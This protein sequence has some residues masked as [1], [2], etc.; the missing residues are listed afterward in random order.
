[1][2]R[3]LN[4]LERPVHTREV[5]SSSLSLATAKALDL[6]GLF[7]FHGHRLSGPLGTGSGVH[8][9]EE[10]AL[11]RKIF[12]CILILILTATLISGCSGKEPEK[13]S[14]SYLTTSE[15]PSIEDYDPGM[16]KASFISAPD[17]LK[18]FSTLP[19]TDHGISKYSVFYNMF[20]KDTSACFVLS[21]GQGLYGDMILVEIKNNSEG[22]F[23]ILKKAEGG[24]V[25][26]PDENSSPVE[27]PKLEG[28]IPGGLGTY[29]DADGSNC[30]EV[31]LSVED[32]QMRIYIN[33]TEAQVPLLTAASPSFDLGSIGVYKERSQS[34]AYID[35]VS[36]NDDETGT[37][38]SD[39][40][41][42]INDGSSGARIGS[43]FK[44]TGIKGQ[45][46]PVF[47]KNFDTRS[48][49][50]KRATLYLTALGSFEASLNGQRVSDDYLD[51][52]ALNFNT[53]LKYVAYDVTPFISDSNTLDITL[54][55]GW[56]DRALGYPESFSPWGDKPALKGEL[57]IEDKKGN[58]TII[59]T[60]ESF[61][62][63]TNG[64]LRFDDIYQGE[65][66]DASYPVTI[67]DGSFTEVEVDA[68]DPSY[69]SLPVTAKK[70]SP[71]RAVETLNPIS[72]S[73]PVPG[74]FV[75]DF[76]TNAVGNISIDLKGQNTDGSSVDLSALGAAQGE[77]L[78]F[79]Y[80]E[81]TNMDIMANT[82]DEIG[83]V[84]TQNLLT[85]GASDRYIVGPSNEGI[86]FR[87]TIHGFRYMQI[88]GLKES[89]PVENISLNVLMSDLEP[90]GTFTCSDELIGRYYENSRRSVLSNF[91]DKPTDCPQRDERLGWA[92]DAQDV[93]LFAS[94]LFDTKDFYIQ[95]LDH[96]CTLQTPEGAFPDTAPRNIGGSGKNCWGDAPVVIAWD[97]Y[98]QYGET[99]ILERYYD[100]C[101][102]WVNYLVD[103]SVDNIREMPSYGDHLAG[104]DTSSVLSDTAWCAHSADIVSKM[105]KVL[106]KEDDAVKYSG[107][108]DDYRKAWLNKYLRPDGSVEAGLLTEESETAYAL[109]IEFELFDEDMMQDAADRLSILCQYDQF[110]FEPGYSGLRYLL[111]A[112]SRYGHAD[113]AY[114]ILTCQMPGSLLYT[115]NCGMT[116]VPES[117]HAFTFTDDQ[118][119][120]VEGSLNHYAYASVCS[121][122]YT[123]ILGIKP[124][125]DHPG[126][127]HFFLK[128]AGGSPIAEVS[129]SYKTKYGDIEVYVSSG[130]YDETHENKI[131]CT[132]PKGTT[133]TLTLPDGTVKDLEAGTYEYDY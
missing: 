103:T 82:D 59:P 98:L 92:G 112:L 33:D 14:V 90:A 48:S 17:S 80:G 69:I 34:Y 32:G 51:P 87:H 124:D 78:T 91:I 129:G 86:E 118:K 55:H 93:C 37:A 57:V 52:G 126:Y 56:Y 49:K 85:A 10:T 120:R 8:F 128:P 123:D 100:N 108:Y 70:V 84:W 4:W 63:S 5:E 117:L 50:V 20:V 65:V 41:D 105:A 23:L 43:G 106:G 54:L 75:Y 72:V 101:V 119:L 28:A 39:A 3:W 102:R 42:E 62:V 131:K 132:V 60:D 96:L 104:Q 130:A 36:I 7:H 29:P 12:S 76:G 67:D 58:V 111:P 11:K 35:S 73:E 16:S 122:M 68:V 2:A 25:S 81:L 88:D 1:M 27:I 109:G 45:P 125:P 9:A 26:L 107:I 113:T 30:F 19:G 89:I 79:T 24:R 83:T 127:E 38:L 71:V 15:L 13:Q 31:M 99:N 47:R 6:Q 77:T 64:P 22:S 18:E 66:Y 110:L 94:Y 21:D 53:E 61:K 116:S 133:C 114:S 115:V 44:L 40:F 95:Y 121:Y 46:A 74:S 97:I